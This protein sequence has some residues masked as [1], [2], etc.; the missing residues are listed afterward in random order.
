[1]IK[2]E[3][4]KK[5]KEINQK[6]TD[7]DHPPAGRAYISAINIGKTVKNQEEGSRKLHKNKDYFAFFRKSSGYEY[8]KR[9]DCADSAEHE[10]YIKLMYSQKLKHTACF[11]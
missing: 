6:I 11:P 9:E 1:M 8:K 7:S 3:N 10:H 2:G 4:Y 5:R